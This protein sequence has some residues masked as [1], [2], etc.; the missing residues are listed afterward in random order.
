MRY[1]SRILLLVA[2]LALTLGVSDDRATAAPVP[3]AATSSQP[4]FEPGLPPAT[5]RFFNRDIV[6]LRSASL[7]F[8]PAERALVASERIRQALANHGPGAV[9]VT[10]TPEGLTFAIDG[11]RVF[12]M[13]EGDL[14]ADDA[15]TF[16]LAQ[17]V[18]GG[19]LQ[20][21]VTAFGQS[22]QGRVL[23]RGLI[24]GGG[25]TLLFGLAVWVLSRARLGIRRRIDAH[26]AGR[27]HLGLRERAVILQLV[28]AIGQIVFVA[29]LAVLIEEWLR[30]V[31]SLFPYT[32]PWADHLTGYIAGIVRQVSSAMADAVPG[33]MM[34]AIIAALAHLAVRIVRTIAGTIE[35]GR[36]RLFGIDADVVQ[37]TRRI[38]TAVL[39]LFALAMAYPY[40]PGSSS[41]AFKGLT[42]L[43]GV[44]LSVGASGVV[45]Q[46]AGGFILAYSRA[47]HK[48][49]WVRVGEVEGAVT[50]VGV[51]ST[52]IRTY[53]DEE[54]SI[55]NTVVL[56]TITRN[57]SRPAT[58]EGAILET[59]VTIGYS[60]P[61]RQVHAMLREAA[62]RT[63]E[64]E[65]EP[66]PDVLQT[67]LSDF[68]VQYSLRARLRNPLRRPAVL[69]A[70]NANVQD[71]FNE[72]GVQIM[73]P[74][75]F[76][77]PDTP[78]V[79]PKER[80]FEPPA[81]E[82]GSMPRPVPMKPPNR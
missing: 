43:V 21:A 16:E 3:Q 63:P 24:L 65:R 38:V 9:T 26:L 73:S 58:G 11:T 8:P 1:L 81:G 35:S 42:V 71:V 70:L 60:A 51:F 66:P 18:V 48:G 44:M 12:R 76:A 57:F 46:A 47:L 27:L 37:P 53:N 7:G 72:H 52:K 25:A 55:P 74:H 49:E 2:Y 17:V 50:T 29:V 20:E 54:V 6:T 33:L 64:L 19:R 31:F 32:G 30:F 22:G 77:D 13:L 59:S 36:Y 28:R 69:S 14:D 5:L 45:G 80:W 75:Y 78:V 34:V 82:S 23:F 39:W 68:Y 41:E 15:Q 56:G 10:R 62:A 61:W 40:L 79:V 67:A 4:S